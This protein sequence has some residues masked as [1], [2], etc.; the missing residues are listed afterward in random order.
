VPDQRG[1]GQTTHTEDGYTILQLATDMASLLEHL[2][3]GPANLVGTS[4]GGAIAQVMA[5]DHPQLVRSV[6]M[7]SSF[8]RADAYMR[9]E[10]ALR[11]KLMVEADLDTVYSCYALFLFAPEYASRNPDVVAAW[12]N[13]AA[14]QPAD[15]EIAVK[16]IDMIMGHDVVSQLGRIKRPTLVVCGDPDICTPLYLSEEIAAGISDAHLSV[17]SGGGHFIHD[18]QPERCFDTVGTFIDRH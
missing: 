6:T 12:I 3:T 11:R 8:A 5:I 7:S 2:Q 9:R 16:R 17:L 10:F 14:S 1:T 4:T 13:R 18:E 15:R